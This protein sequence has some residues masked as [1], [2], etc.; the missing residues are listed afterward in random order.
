MASN[1]NS[2][3]PLEHSRSLKLSPLRAHLRV[4]L[5]LV[6]LLLLVLFISVFDTISIL[7]LFILQVLR[8]P[9]LSV[10]RL[11]TLICQRVV[12]QSSFFGHCVPFYRSKEN[13]NCTFALTWPDNLVI[14]NFH[15]A[16]TEYLFVE[17]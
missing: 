15:V 1:E 4:P 2:S 11:R 12:W 17:L 14:G 13:P 3:L 16:V 8:R 5:P 9:L 10:T 7:H 6:V